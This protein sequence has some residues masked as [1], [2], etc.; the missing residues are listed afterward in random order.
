MTHIETN[1]FDHYLSYLFIMF[2]S[3]TTAWLLGN[4][5]HVLIRY[6]YPIIMGLLIGT[7]IVNF[8]KRK[9]QL[10]LLEMC[11][12]VNLVSII[13]IP[14][15]YDIRYIYPF[16]HG[17]LMTYSLVYG[18]S[19]VPHNLEKTT[20]YAIH[21]IGSIISR[22]LYWNGDPSLWLTINDLTFSSFLKHFSTSM[23]VYMIWALPYY[24]YLFSYNGNL[25]TMGKYVYRLNPEDQ[26]TLYLKIKYAFLHISFASLTLMIGI[27]SMH[28][29]QFNYFTVG[30][31][32]LSGFL[33]GGWYYYTGH[34]LNF[35]KMLVKTFLTVK[36]TV[37]IKVNNA[38][39]KIKEFGEIYDKKE[40]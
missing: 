22:R 16:L 36:T 35:F 29:W 9:Y 11:Y 27:L 8:Y 1:L 6:W 17:P 19:I 14:L 12:V 10:Y 25:M 24:F 2:C 7:R 20:S 18:D 26:L 30:C 15:E 28:C 31:Q 21:S 32:I 38:I 4:N 37:K 3:I 5:D 39:N 13:I 40:V 23:I 34:K 33:H